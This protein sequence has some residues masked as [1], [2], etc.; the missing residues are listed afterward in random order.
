MFQNGFFLGWED[1]RLRE[2]VFFS[3]VYTY[4]NSPSLPYEQPKNLPDKIDS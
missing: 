1:K 2:N 3:S 4:G